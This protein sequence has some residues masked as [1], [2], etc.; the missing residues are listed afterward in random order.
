MS[1]LRGTLAL[2]LAMTANASFLTQLQSLFQTVHDHPLGPLLPHSVDTQLQALVILM[3]ISRQLTMNQQG[4]RALWQVNY[5]HSQIKPLCFPH[6]ED[7]K[8][9][10]TSAE[11]SGRGDS[12]G[13]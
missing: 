12:W 6:S 3:T 9:I 8:Q 1:L 2:N 5:K 7:Y 10:A 4:L 13:G 11:S